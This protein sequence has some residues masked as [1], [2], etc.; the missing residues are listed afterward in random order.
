MKRFVKDECPTP[1][2][3]SKV[4]HLVFSL[5][6]SPLSSVDRSCCIVQGPIEENDEKI[7]GF[8]KWF[9]YGNWAGWKEMM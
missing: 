6:H 3:F 1:W 7:R 4:E 5:H 2:E 8:E 9:Y